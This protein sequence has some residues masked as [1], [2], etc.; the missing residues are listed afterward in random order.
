MTTRMMLSMYDEKPYY[1]KSLGNVAS[2][3]NF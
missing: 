1:K 2:M 3:T